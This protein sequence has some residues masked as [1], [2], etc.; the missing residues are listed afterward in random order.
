MKFGE[1][2]TLKVTFG[3]TLRGFSSGWNCPTV[4]PTVSRLMRVQSASV[5]G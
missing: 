2:G 5:S 3:I 1:L 4:K